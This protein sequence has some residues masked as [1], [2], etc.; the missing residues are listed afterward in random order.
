[1]G[2]GF[3]QKSTGAN[4]RTRFSTNTCA[5]SCFVLTE[6]PKISGN[7]WELPGECNL[8]ILYSSS[9]LRLMG[10]TV[11][12]MDRRGHSDRWT[13]GRGGEWAGRP[14]GRCVKMWREV[15]PQSQSQMQ[16]N[17]HV[18]ICICECV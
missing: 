15:Y 18:L 17:V 2:A 16:V 8:G 12:W 11:R 6:S 7:L 9:L 10:T 1:M 13:G 14:A 4:G 3:R 5:G